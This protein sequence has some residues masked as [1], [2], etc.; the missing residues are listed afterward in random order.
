MG[1]SSEFGAGARASVQPLQPL[2]GLPDAPEYYHTVTA[3]LSGEGVRT[4]VSLS[5][6]NNPTEQARGHSEKNWE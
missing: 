5:Q 6:D 4:T 1:E 3:E 2:S